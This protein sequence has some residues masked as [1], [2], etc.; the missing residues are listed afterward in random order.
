MIV[1]DKKLLE[2][3]KTIKTIITV[4]ANIICVEFNFISSTSKKEVC[5]T[6]FN[7]V[8][9]PGESLSSLDSQK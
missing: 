6:F 4:K 9:V 2:P 1:K 8:P 7:A 3:C 5:D